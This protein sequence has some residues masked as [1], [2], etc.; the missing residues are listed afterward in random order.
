MLSL[1]SWD[2]WLP[3][4]G[5]R[6]FMKEIICIA[7]VAL[8]F[9]TAIE[10]QENAP[11]TPDNPVPQLVPG[12]ARPAGRAAKDADAVVPQNVPLT[13]PK[14]TSL[15]VALDKEVRIQKVGQ[16]VSAQVIEPVYAFDRLVVP[17]GSEV[18]GEVSRI[19]PV[20]RGKRTVAGVDGD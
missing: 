10:A 8:T 19:A 14:G 4:L 9:V 12:T 13:V 18:L 16:R 15:Q 6:D 3:P 20:P 11:T 1:E 5:G 7:V 2:S 17:A